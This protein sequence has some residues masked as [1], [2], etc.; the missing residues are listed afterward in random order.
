MVLQKAY[1]TC[2]GLAIPIDCFIVWL[3]FALSDRLARYVAPS[4]MLVVS[5][6]MNILMGAIGISFM[7]RGAL[8][9][10]SLVAA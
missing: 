10:L 8:A 7:I 6:V 5:K 2:T 3:L 9:I 1:R 4:V